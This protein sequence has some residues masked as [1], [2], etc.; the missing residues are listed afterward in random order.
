VTLPLATPAAASQVATPKPA[1]VDVPKQ[2]LRGTPAAATPPVKAASPA[3]KPTPGPERTPPK[4]PSSPRDQKPKD[5]TETTTVG[6]DVKTDT[7]PP[8]FS[9]KQED[10]QAAFHGKPDKGGKIQHSMVSPHSEQ[11]GTTQRRWGS[12]HDDIRYFDK[13]NFDDVQKQWQRLTAS[14]QCYSCRV[15]KTDNNRTMETMEEVIQ[16]FIAEGDRIHRS[17][18]ESIELA[19][20]HWTNDM[21]HAAVPR[22]SDKPQSWYDVHTPGI[23]EDRKTSIKDDVRLQERRT[24]LAKSIIDNDRDNLF[25]CGTKGGKCT[26]QYITCTYWQM[27]Q[28]GVTDGKGRV[29]TCAYGTPF[30]PGKCPFSHKPQEELDQEVKRLKPFRKAIEFIQARIHADDRKAIPTELI[31]ETPADTYPWQALYQTMPTIMDDF[32][33]V[34]HPPP[35]QK[36]QGKHRKGAGKG[37]YTPKGKGTYNPKGKDTPAGW[38]PT[39]TPPPP[40]PPTQGAHPSIPP[41]IKAGGAAADAYLDD[42]AKQHGYPSKGKGSAP[43]VDASSSQSKGTQDIRKE[44]RLALEQLKRKSQATAAEAEDESNKSRKNDVAIPSRFAGVRFHK[45]PRIAQLA[46]NRS[47]QRVWSE[48]KSDT[49]QTKEDDSEQT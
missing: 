28:D 3:V 48:K 34:P 25:W 37:A 4:P 42:I 22:L 15:N 35:A 20:A 16:V 43:P 32:A 41:A 2:D 33:P 49:D 24:S 13:F 21:D 44:Q 1:V 47:G 19:R 38:E 9:A 40:P 23:P 29:K 26:N 10:A 39:P 7:A 17:H 36:G 27:E 5:A 18:E 6:T 8:V 46:A 12:W 31:K 11:K 30:K 45:P 14:G